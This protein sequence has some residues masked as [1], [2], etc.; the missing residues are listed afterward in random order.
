MKFDYRK[1]PNFASPNKMWVSRPFIP[2]RLS[3]NSK[4]LDVYALV[5]SGA[6]TC[7]FHSSIGEELEIEIEEGRK[8]M[9]FGI[10]D[11]PI[12]VYF[13]RIRLQIMG[14][15]G[16]IEIEAG[17]TKSSKVGALLGQSGFFENYH[18]KFERDKER[19]EIT[20]IIKR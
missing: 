4:H 19:F 20:P 1:Q 11:V 16:F 12:D 14:D 9:F 6:D 3:A 10:S 7:L 18:V 13:H 15:S 17:F 2:V 8:E 5:D